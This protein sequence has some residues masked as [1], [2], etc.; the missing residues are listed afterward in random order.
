MMNKIRIYAVGIV[1]ICLSQMAWA[2]KDTPATYALHPWQ[3]VQPTAKTEAYFTNIPADGKVEMPFVLKFGLSGGW[4]LA[5]IAKPMGGKSGHHHLLINTPLPLDISKPIAFTE[6]Y[7]HFGKGQMETVLNLAP[8]THT[9]RMLLADHEHKLHFVFS[10]EQTITVTKKNSDVDPKSLT[11]KEIRLINIAAG[12]AFNTPFR[13]QF[14]AAG[15]NVAHMQQKEKDTG[16][17]RLFLT[18]ANGGKQAEIAFAN[19]Q[20]EVWLSPPA[21]SYKLKLELVSNEIADK[22]LAISEAIA[23]QVRDLPQ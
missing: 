16:H 10:K 19:G 12:D 20:T 11:K 2:Q 6:K 1:L 17:F 22:V 4:G 21:G 13:V 7:V 18:P 8:G 14:H 5:P 3:A 23:I 9:L 15:F